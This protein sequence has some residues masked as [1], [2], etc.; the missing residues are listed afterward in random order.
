MSSL[1]A[2]LS[3]SGRLLID[4]LRERVAI[5]L[6]LGTGMTYVILIPFAA[7]LG[8]GWSDGA[9][10][11]ARVRTIVTEVFNLLAPLGAVLFANQLVSRERAEN[12]DR[13][14]FARPV[15]PAAYYATKWAMAGAAL[16]LVSAIG[17]TGASVW[18]GRDVI[19]P[20]LTMVTAAYVT[21]GGVLFLAS[22]L[23]VTDWKGLVAVIVPTLAVQR[24]WNGTD[25]ARGT[26]AGLMPAWDVA[27]CA[28]RALTGGAEFGTPCIAA[29]VL[30]ATAFVVALLV[31]RR[32]EVG[33]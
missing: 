31:I 7:Q 25:G 20:V 26:I 8:P 24:L 21:F 15:G 19:V 27:A 3:Y 18:L 5:F 33:V 10:G 9:D 1:G 13:L 16:L 22:T 14:I 17:V 29:L 12:V 23:L 6:V 4:V 11:E 30:G 2:L 32:R 28:G